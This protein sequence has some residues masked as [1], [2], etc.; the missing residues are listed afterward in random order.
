M[1]DAMAPRELMEALDRLLVV[2]RESTKRNQLAIRQAEAIRKLHRGGQSYREIFVRDERSLIRQVTSD[3]V[4]QLVEASAK[5]RWAEA[6]ALHDEGL[7]MDKIADLFG[8]TRQRISALL[9]EGGSPPRGAAEAR[10]GRR[11][12]QPPGLSPRRPSLSPLGHPP[13]WSGRHNSRCASAAVP[14]PFG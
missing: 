11:S 10:V 2:F 1:T 14:F 6:K 3:N 12:G 13:R 9:R 4:D 7:T 5:L 8:L